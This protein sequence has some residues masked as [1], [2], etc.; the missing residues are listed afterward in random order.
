MAATRTKGDGEQGNEGGWRRKRKMKTKGIYYIIGVMLLAAVEAQAGEYRYRLHLDGKPG[1]EVVKW[2]DRALERRARFGIQTDSLDLEISPE[3]IRR[4]EEA[5]LTVLTRSRWLNTVVVM[6]AEGEAVSDSTFEAL[7]FVKE[8]ELITDHQRVTAPSRLTMAPGIVGEEDCT[9]PLKEVNA[10]EPLYEAGYRGAGMLVAVVDAGYSHVDEWD[11]M[12]H[13]VVGGRDMYAA[14]RGESYLYKDEMHGTCCLS[15]MATPLERGICGTAQDA[16]YYLMVSESNESETQMEEDMWVAAVE[17]ADSLGA[18]VVSSSLGYFT[19]DT[20]FN[21]HNYDEFS[22]DKAVISRGANVAGKKGMLV[23][24][25]AGNERNKSWVRLTFPADAEDVLAVGAVTPAGEVAY[26]SSAGFTVPY[27]KPDVMGRGTRCYIVTSRGGV[28]SNGQGTSYAT[29]FIAGLCTSLWSAVPQL[30]AAQIRQV[31]RESA[32]QYNEPDS[33]M[34]YGI[35]D[36][37]VALEKAR[38]LVEEMGI[39]ELR[40]DV[41]RA[42]ERGYDLMGRPL[43]RKAKG[44]FRVVGGRVERR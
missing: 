24:V 8:V 6:G 16:K 33:L 27:V 30:T 7:P 28:S 44:G 10:Y 21:D 14:M 32:S 11:W 19:Y 18:D 23:C 41:P 20:E 25:A 35:P 22:Q 29:P 12:N 36:F 43:G 15:I 39:D 37:G 1:S 38:V 3:Y 31:V 13:N 4:I 2:S 42:E 9:T 40:A 26:F 5:G 34:G 17:L